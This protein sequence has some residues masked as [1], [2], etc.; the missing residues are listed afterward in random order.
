MSMNIHDIKQYAV[1]QQALIS[2]VIDACSH[3]DDN[4]DL[5]SLS[6][7][8]FCRVISLLNAQKKAL[9]IENWFNKKL[10]LFRLSPSL[11]AGDASSI[12]IKNGII[13]PDVITYEYKFSTTNEAR[14]LNLRQIRNWQCIDYYIT[15]YLDY[16][17]PS[18]SVLL[19]IP[20]NDMNHEILRLGTPTHGTSNAN[21]K[22]VN[23]EYSITVKLDSETMRSWVD[24]YSDDVLNGIMKGNEQ[25]NEQ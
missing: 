2:N 13:T 7:N 17:N 1:K 10:G 12:V 4:D 15:G 21:R 5:T 20:K 14:T 18:E 22:N 6:F 24:K 25:Q 16:H 19:R 3:Y 23:I 8:D 9:L 11:N